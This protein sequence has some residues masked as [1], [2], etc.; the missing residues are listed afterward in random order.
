MLEAA[1]TQRAAL[2]LAMTMRCL[3]AQIQ[4]PFCGS[5]LSFSSAHNT[6][7]RSAIFSTG[8]FFGLLAQISDAR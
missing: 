2:Q 7:L 3:Q 6:A 1:M 5:N 8:C 4:V